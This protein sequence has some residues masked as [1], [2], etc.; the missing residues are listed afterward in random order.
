MQF[1]KTNM[2]SLNKS[3][4]FILDK[5]D[6]FAE[7]PNQHLLYNLYD[8]AANSK[9]TIPIC[10][11]GITDRVDVLEMFEKRVKSRFSHR[12]INVCPTYDFDKYKEIAQRLISFKEM[13]T[14]TNDTST[15]KKKRHALSPEKL[16]WNKDVET[17][18]T[19]IEVQRT[20]R[21][22]FDMD[23]TILKLSSFLVKY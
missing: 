14:S 18:F 11:I 17:L 9:S 23:P 16:D 6:L 2:E 22:V 8:L 21:A 7:H 3:I 12:N 1:L 13:P 19:N 5:L 4:I 10:I 20:L 15:K